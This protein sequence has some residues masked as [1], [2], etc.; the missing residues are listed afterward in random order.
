MPVSSISKFNRL[1]IDERVK[2]VVNFAELTAE[3]VNTLK[4]NGS[5]PREIADRMIENY[6]TN[7]EIPM[8]IATNF[9]INGKDHLIPMAIE[10]PSV[11]AGCSYAAKIAR[12]TGGFT[13]HSSES[14]MIGQIQVLD[15]PS[16][17]SAVNELYKGKEE[18]INIANEKSKTLTALG[19]GARDL[20]TVRYDKPKEML[21]V[22]LVV[23]VRDAMGANIVNSMCEHIAPKIEDITK[24][25]TNLKIVSNLSDLRISTST[26]KF[27]SDLIG[28]SRVVENFIDAYNFAR[29]DIHRAASHNKGIMN[30][31]DA[32]LLATLNDWRAV[33]AGA[34]SYF[35]RDGYGPFTEYRIDENG[36]IVGSIKIPLSLGLIGGST[37][38]APKSVIARKI[39]GVNSSREFADVVAAVGLAQ[40]FAALRALS[41][42]GIQKGHMK[43]HSRSIAISA[44]AIGEQVDRVSSILISEG[45]ISL[46]RA[47]E[48]LDRLQKK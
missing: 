35:S 16:S 46:S 2:E 44:G 48:V 24:G 12:K 13:S 30:G 45:N 34:H 8:G 6:V 11:I 31:V 15:I 17:T 19:A 4:N 40:N 23:D 7:I 36:D 38:S 47:K 42:E 37:R 22:N 39:L 1:T 32:V 41:N 26:A 33:E 10:E 21:V 27:R 9:L 18:I 3:D 43:L 25:R 14:L 20:Y 29:A 5:L 28:G